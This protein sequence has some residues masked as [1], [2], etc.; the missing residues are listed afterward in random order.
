MAKHGAKDVRKR[1][2]DALINLALVHPCEVVLDGILCRNDLAVR[3]VEFVNGSIKSSCF[4]RTRRP[5]NQEDTVWPFDDLFESGVVI[6]LK[7]KCRHAQADA[8]GTQDT[9]Y[10]AFAVVSR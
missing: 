7:P 2:T 1:Q 3:P 9:Q 5:R 10:D 6:R 4:A 8:F